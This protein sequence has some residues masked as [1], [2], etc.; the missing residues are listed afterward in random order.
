MSATDPGNDLPGG[1]EAA[2]AE[3]VLGLLSED[4]ARVFE[5]RMATD[6]DLAQDVQAWSEY[7]ATLTDDLPEIEAPLQVLQRAE[8]QALATGKPPV[9]RALWPYLAGAVAA[10]LL[11]WL[12]LSGD[13]LG[14]GG[15]P[16]RAELVPADGTITLTAAFDPTDATLRLGPVVG[17]A[18]EGRA[19]ELWLIAAPD[20][21]PV[22]L[23][24]V[25]PGGAVIALPPLLADRLNGATLAVSD[26]P[27]GGSPTGAPT[28]AV[29]AA[30]TLAAS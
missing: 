16:L 21:A 11:A 3:Y 24:L 1:D 26:E 14:P 5:A 19:L 18:P 8:A 6:P 22:S 7:F 4:E 29:L 12:V 15:T 13:L 9:W 30:G 20:A 17:T 10:S 28:G 23:G 25:P 27:P 2:A